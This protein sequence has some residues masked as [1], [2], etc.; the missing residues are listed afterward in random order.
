MADS[1]ASEGNK[2]PFLYWCLYDYILAKL[3]K[4]VSLHAVCLVCLAPPPSTSG[5]GIYGSLVFFYW[6]NAYLFSA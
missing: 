6:S 1:I 5:G 4:S 2:N 3:Q